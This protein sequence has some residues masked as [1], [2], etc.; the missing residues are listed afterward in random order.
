M[1]EDERKPEPE[2]AVTDDRLDAP[3]GAII[4]DE[5]R[6]AWYER[7]LDSWN[8]RTDIHEL[9]V[10]RL[11]VVANPFR[12]DPWGIGPLTRLTVTRA[13]N[14]LRQKYSRRGDKPMAGPCWAMKGSKR[15]RRRWHVERVA[16]LVVYG[17]D[18]PIEI[19]VGVPSLGCFPDWIVQDGNHRLAAAIY[20]GRRTIL[21]SCGGQQSAIDEY[22]A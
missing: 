21:A 7:S 13:I 6:K 1:T 22:V 9:S 18:D 10:A 2:F 11:S 4:Y 20:L 14:R 17:W 8:L 15:E 16:W 3:D 12:H 5:D 19:D